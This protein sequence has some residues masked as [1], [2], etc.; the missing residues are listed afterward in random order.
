M[1]RKHV[2]VLLASAAIVEESQLVHSS[3][4]WAAATSGC[5]YHHVHLHY[6]H[7]ILYLGMTA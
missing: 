5:G 7:S 1:P 2:Q 3:D 4:L 6:N